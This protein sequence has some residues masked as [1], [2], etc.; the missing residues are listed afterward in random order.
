MLSDA[1]TAVD[2]SSFSSCRNGQNG[3][4]FSYIKSLNIASDEKGMPCCKG[5]Y[6]V[7]NTT[8]IFF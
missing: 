6:L 1:A 3:V 7:H 5:T 2:L 8:K 4:T